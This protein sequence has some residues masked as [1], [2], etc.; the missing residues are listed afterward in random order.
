M[1]SSDKKVCKDDFAINLKSSDIDKLLGNVKHEN[2]NVSRQ[3]KNIL[4]IKT[5][6]NQVILPSKFENFK[7]YRPLSKLPRT[8]LAVTEKLVR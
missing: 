2:A 7:L 4:D 1:Q 5:T 8:A 6:D 3:L